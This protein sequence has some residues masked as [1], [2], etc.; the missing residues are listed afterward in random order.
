[1][2]ASYPGAIKSFTQQ[3]DLVDVIDAVDVNSAYDEIEAI[4][5][6]L[7]ID[8]AGTAI[9]LTTRLARTIDDIGNLEFNFA[10]ELTIVAGVI[11]TTQNYHLI[12]TESDDATDDLDTIN[13]GAEGFTLIIRPID[14]GRTIVVKDGTGNL[15][16]AGDFSMDSFVDMLV[17]FKINATE[18]A[19]LSRSNNE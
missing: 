4:E 1:M 14:D 13:G 18:W 12:D 2:A 19:E 5:T 9:D 16:L 3:T 17:L 8:P 15:K 7:G 10:T 11:T 6:E